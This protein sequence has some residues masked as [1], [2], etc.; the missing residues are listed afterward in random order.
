M[1]G[2]RRWQRDHHARVEL[3]RAQHPARQK[4]ARWAPFLLHPKNLRNSTQEALDINP[5]L[6]TMKQD[7]VS[8]ATMRARPAFRHQSGFSLLEV[9]LAVGVAI[10]L[11]SMQLTQIR[12]DTERTQA[13]AAG[14]QLE[15][16]G[17]ALNT[18]IG[19]THGQLINGVSVAGAG[20]VADPGPRTCV[21][22]VTGQGPGWQCT[23]TTETLQRA[24]ILPMA[25]S[26][27]NSFG[28][29]YDYVI[30]VQGTAP[31]WRVDGLVR[32][33]TAYT[34][35][36]QVREDLIGQALARAGSDSGAVIDA[37]GTINGLSGIWSDD[38]W[39]FGTPARGMLGYRVGYG[40]SGFNSLLRTDGSNAFTNDLD[41]GSA[42]I[43]N[44][45][46]ATIENDVRSRR[47]VTQ[48]TRSDAII[49]GTDDPANQAVLGN[50]GNRL[51]IQTAGG[52][53]LVDGAGNGV[54]LSAGNITVGSV[55][56][57]G[58]AV[59]G[60]PVSSQGMSTTG[61]QNIGSTGGISADGDFVTGNGDFQTTNGNFNTTNGNLSAMGGTVRAQDLAIGGSASIGN[62]LR[63]GSTGTNG[64]FY[65]PGTNTMTLGGT[66][67]LRIGADPGCDLTGGTA[68]PADDCRVHANSVVSDG[69]LTAARLRIEA[70]QAP[71]A[72]CLSSTFATDSTGRMMECV[73]GVYTLMGG[74][75]TI[76]VRNSTIAFAG[77]Q[78]SIA[79]PAGYRMVGGGWLVTQR[80]TPA[81]D[82][83]A[84]SKSFG[85]SGANSWTIENIGTGHT[86]GFQAQ[87]VC[88]QS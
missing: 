18:Y 23:V 85:N 10:T 61:G 44:A 13:E 7:H 88:A 48:A 63:F 24:G 84:P 42:S 37:G 25:F 41:M 54:P 86:A 26:G 59:F 30:R 2:C 32:T 79:C 45:G 9:L 15:M 40:A 72:S 62:N 21:A 3:I 27:T 31:D 28:A 56:S 67:N 17:K 12:A 39:G 69:T 6:A 71:G 76:T 64:W 43:T 60:A 55:T 80:N 33:D 52:V 35:G 47:L 78:V 11:G 4:G 50:N 66:S 75:R 8:L 34:T 58:A 81:T 87:V 51:R 29:N 49:M 53:Q 46:E 38:T 65:T 16:A 5:T 82:P 73:S 19:L 83:Y 14:R 70:Q 77:Q 74:A 68:S 20:T 1:Q 57:R 36:G 22:I